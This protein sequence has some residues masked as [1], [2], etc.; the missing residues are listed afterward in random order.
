MK[1]DWLYW[2]LWV[3]FVMLLIYGFRY[4]HAWA[5]WAAFG[6]A[7]LNMVYSSYTSKRLG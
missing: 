4:N 1:I 6:V 5:R 2:W 3:L 7:G